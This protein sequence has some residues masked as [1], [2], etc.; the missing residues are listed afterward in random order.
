MLYTISHSPSYSFA[1]S[2][3]PT[4]DHVNWRDRDSRSRGE[5]ALLERSATRS[6]RHSGC[7]AYQRPSII[8]YRR[9]GYF[10][11][12]AC[13]GSHLPSDINLQSLTAYRS[14]GFRAQTTFRCL[15]SSEGGL[16]GLPQ[17]CPLLSQRSHQT[18]FN[19]Q[20]LDICAF[21]HPQPLQTDLPGCLPP[22]VHAALLWRLSGWQSNPETALWSCHRRRNG[23]CGEPDLQPGNERGWRNAD[24]RAEIPE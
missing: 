16:Q 10:F 18:R 15:D 21:F 5:L 23:R 17:P 3:H 19:S 20:G 7:C 24:L 13:S 12:T 11:I 14:H 4:L 22:D 1:P 8:H 6:G 9:G 2:L